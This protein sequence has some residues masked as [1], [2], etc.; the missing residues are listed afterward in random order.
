[1]SQR[2]EW[3]SWVMMDIQDLEEWRKVCQAGGMEWVRLG[4]GK[5]N[6]MVKE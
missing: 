5:G 3:P 4:G 6:N 2:R 1:M